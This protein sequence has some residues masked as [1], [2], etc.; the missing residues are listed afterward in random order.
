MGDVSNGTG[1]PAAAQGQGTIAAGEPIAATANGGAPAQGAETSGGNPAKDAAAE[2]IRKHK[3]KVDGEE[4]EVDEEELKRGYAHQK[5]ANKK[6]QEGLR[7]RKQSEDFI[8]AM[9][10]P[11][12]L[13]DTLYKMGYTQQQ[14]RQISENYLAQVLEEEMLDPKDRELKTTKQKLQEFEKKE[15][16][17]KAQEEHAHNEA[18]KKKYAEQ[19]SAEFIEALKT[20]GLPPTK[21]M[22]ADMA[23]Y[24]SRAAKIKMPM[25]AIEAAKL[26]QEDVVIKN[27]H[28]FA[29]MNPADIVKIVGEEGLK[30]LREFDVSRLRDPNASLKTP[31]DQAEANRSKKTETK[32]MSPAEW[33]A[34]NRK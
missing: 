3:L 4:I 12:T 26:V 20:T 11:G 6:L 5:A 23:K 17:R 1:A 32:R 19:Y 25:T 9:K 13:V 16:D 21:D 10:D 7:Y 15:A 31:V 34:F 2:A 18:L 28:L 8:K 30:K 27:Q 29:N 14:V 22:V 24:I 33:R